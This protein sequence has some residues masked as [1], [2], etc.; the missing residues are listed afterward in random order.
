LIY[1]VSNLVLISDK[2]LMNN[3]VAKIEIIWVKKLTIFAA[4][5]KNR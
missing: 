5:Q 3:E 1:L 4:R 2:K